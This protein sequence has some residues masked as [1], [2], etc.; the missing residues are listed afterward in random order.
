MLFQLQLALPLLI[1][2]VDGVGVFKV[3]MNDL[4]PRNETTLCVTILIFPFGLVVASKSCAA[5][6]LGEK[7]ENDL[8]L[9][10]LIAKE[11]KINIMLSAFQ[12]E[13]AT[14]RP[15]AHLLLDFALG[16]RPWIVLTT[17]ARCRR[18][19]GSFRHATTAGTDANHESQ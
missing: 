10:V 8:L 6:A 19:R 17:P 1:V 2:D 18:I 12:D 3:T 5:G 13:M 11:D 14:S 4:R 16:E 9:V 7:E 15:F